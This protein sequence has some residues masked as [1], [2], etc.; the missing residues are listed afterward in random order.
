MQGPEI[1]FC[2]KHP[3][4]ATLSGGTAAPGPRPCLSF[5]AFLSRA[6]AAPSPDAPQPQA[7]VR[8][9]HAAGPWTPSKD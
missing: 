6:L 5:W 9:L 8:T 7:T 2:G 1:T 3:W 4:Q